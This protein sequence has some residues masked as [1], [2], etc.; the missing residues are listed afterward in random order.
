[1]KIFFIVLL[2]MF[3]QIAFSANW[4]F[5]SKSIGNTSY[6]DR[7]SIKKGIKPKAWFL[8]DY[9]EPS[10]YNDFSH[11]EYIEANCKEGTLRIIKVA[12]FN[13]NMGNGE[14]TFINNPKNQIDYPVPGSVNESFFTALCVSK[15]K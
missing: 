3:H 11:I 15:S 6:I 1:M 14:A 10:K 13:G 2:V 5:V 8:M 9:S 12:T 7:T 4:E